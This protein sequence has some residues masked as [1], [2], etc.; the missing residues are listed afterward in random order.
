MPISTTTELF[1]D[2]V[3]RFGQTDYGPIT[4]A[5]DTSVTRVRVKGGLSLEWSTFTFPLAGESVHNRLIHGIQ[6]GPSGY[7]PYSLLPT[8]VDI[9]P[10]WYGYSAVVPSEATQYFIV[11]DGETAYHSARYKVDLDFLTQWHIGD[12]VED[13]YYSVGLMTLTDNFYAHVSFQTWT[14]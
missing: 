9:I 11:S 3:A 5:G 6:H 2:S 1:N 12:A 13:W 4:I 10:T 8:D 7:S 14:A